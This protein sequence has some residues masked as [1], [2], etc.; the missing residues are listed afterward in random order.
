VS[1]LVALA[2]VAQTTALVVASL[3][4]AYP[5]VAYGHN[6]AHTGGLAF[7]TGAFVA[8]T[9]SYVAFSVFDLGLVSAALDLLAALSLAAAMWAFARPF[10]RFDDTD[11]E[12]PSV[13]ELA[14]SS[15]DEPTG[16]FESAEE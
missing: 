15:P 12:A 9:A 1:D 2:F 7:L 5:L 6:V 11:P 10:V 16:G 3:F 8:T 14:T 13:R 4:L